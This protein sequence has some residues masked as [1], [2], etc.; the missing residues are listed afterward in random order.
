MRLRS[1]SVAVLLA[2]ALVPVTGSAAV[3]HESRTTLS[4]VQSTYKT[5]VG[6]RAKRAAR[7]AVAPA[8]TV[9]APVASSTVVSYADRLLALTNAERKARG[10]R[11]LALSACAAG[12]ADAWAGK[13]AAVGALSHQAL[14][15]IMTTC[16]ARGAGENVA[17]GNV[18]PEQ[19]MAMWMASA[20]HRANILNAGYT[21]LGV[22]TTRTSSGRTYGVQVFLTV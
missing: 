5:S 7:K 11:P 9:T 18:T 12:F 3:A 15:P 6:Q 2:A 22:G 16:R 1:L 8:P 21:H 4:G 13:L 14:T 17:Y 20:G 10:L 19:M